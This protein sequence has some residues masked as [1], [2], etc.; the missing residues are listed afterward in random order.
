LNKQHL[1]RFQKADVI[2]IPIRRTVGVLYRIDW[3]K[4][5]IETR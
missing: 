5:A 3:K 2:H 4:Y 1:A